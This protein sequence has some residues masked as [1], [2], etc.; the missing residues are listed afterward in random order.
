MII[1]RREREIEKE[2]FDNRHT[3]N[4]TKCSGLS[5]ETKRERKKEAFRQLNG[6]EFEYFLTF[7]IYIERERVVYLISIP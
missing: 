5:R 6:I 7:I 4:S 2:D 1:R 3:T